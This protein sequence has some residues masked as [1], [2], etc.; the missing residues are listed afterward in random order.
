[1][2]TIATIWFMGISPELIILVV[3]GALMFGGAKKIPELFKGMGQ[4]IKEFKKGMEEGAEEDKPNDE[5]KD[6][7]KKDEKK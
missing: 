2:N 7:E 5:K 1:M 4:G 3:V 6:D